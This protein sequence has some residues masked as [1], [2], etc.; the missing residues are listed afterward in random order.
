MY[1]GFLARIGA[2][3]SALV[4][5]FKCIKLDLIISSDSKAGASVI[6]SNSISFGHM[7]D[8]FHY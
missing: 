6:S 4:E 5:V 8:N 2:G 7:S 1:Q 3:S